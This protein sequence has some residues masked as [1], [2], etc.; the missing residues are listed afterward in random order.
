MTALAR[1][2]WRLMPRAL[3]SGR[4]DLA[5]KTPKAPGEPGARIKLQV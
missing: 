5:H 1:I 2:L 3:R 4:D